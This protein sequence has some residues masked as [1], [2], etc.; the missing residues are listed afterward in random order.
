MKIVVCIKQVPDSAT[1]EVSADTGV[2]KREGTDGK[3]NPYDLYALET[4][5]RLKQ[6]LGAVVTV[7]TMGP[8]GARDIIKEAFSMGADEGVLLTDRRFAG[9]DVLATSTTL[10]GGIGCLKGVD[11]ILCG[12]QTVDGDTAQ[13][14][15]SIAEHLGI[16][17]IS[18]VQK[19]LDCSKKG[20]RVLQNMGEFTAEAYMDFPCLIT[21]EKDIYSP[22]LPSYRLKKASADRS[23]AV[24][25]LSELAPS[26]KERV[27]LSGS[28]TQVE[29]IFPPEKAAH[30]EVWNF[31]PQENARRLFDKLT[32]LKAI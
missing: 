8:P 29:R 14:G 10:A 2:L 31:S 18:W 15:P 1:V 16:P 4:A 28:P 11:L 6:S 13:V 23:I 26:L 22:R 9:A 30:T 7:I 25:G 12:I 5:L 17:H 27:G 3:L 20:I 21:V 24:L 19:I 32:E